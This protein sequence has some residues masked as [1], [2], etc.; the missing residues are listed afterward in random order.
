M[1]TALRSELGLDK[2]AHVQYLIWLGRLFDGTFGGRSFESGELIANLVAKQLPTTLLLAAYTI[3]LSICWA[4]P[5]GFISSQK[6]DGLLDRI[7]RGFSVIGVSLPNILAASF[8][9]L[10]LLRIFKW[11]PPIIYSTPGESLLEHLGITLWP[12]LILSF[13]YGS[14]VL[15][16]FRTG[17]IKTLKSPYIRGARAR[18]VS[19][20]SLLF[21]HAM[22][23]VG[24]LTLSVA[25]AHFGS[26]ISGALVLEAIFGIPGVGRGLVQAAIARDYPV[27]QSYAF[28]LVA[29]FLVL[30]IVADITH[31]FLDPRQRS[32]LMEKS[33]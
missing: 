26:L 4:L 10:G 13:E 25:V 22:P 31:R 18:G 32:T 23:P 5:A 27:I 7:I 20:N 9:L 19:P 1:R 21:R 24:V 15:Q 11:S 2:P 29:L 16:V 3:V 14:H 12:V 8:I 33:Q 6:P 17:L 28:L 30:Q